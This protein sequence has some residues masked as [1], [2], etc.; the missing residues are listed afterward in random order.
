M[1]VDVDRR[2]LLALSAER[3]DEVWNEVFFGGAGFEDFFFVFDDYF[4]I[5]DFDDFFARDE[6]FGVHNTFDDGAFDDDLLD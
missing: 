3:I 6:K 5:G 4:I 2:E 1:I